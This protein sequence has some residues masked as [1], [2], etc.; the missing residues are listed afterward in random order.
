MAFFARTVSILSVA[1]ALCLAGTNPAGKNLIGYYASWQ[2]YARSNAAAPSKLDL[3]RWSRVNFAFM[4]VAQD[5]SLH[6]TDSY[7]DPIVLFGTQNW[8]DPTGDLSR[9]VTFSALQKPWTATGDQEYNTVAPTVVTGRYNKGT[10]LI[11]LAHA[12]GTKVYLSVGGWTLST[13]FTVV[14]ASAT[15]RAKFAGECARVVRDWGIDGI[16]IDWEYPGFADHKG[17]PA[18]KANYV[19]MLQ[20]IKDSL[21]AVTVATGQAYGLTAAMSCGSSKIDAGIDVTALLPILDEWNLMTYDLNGAW[22]PVANHNSPLFYNGIGDSSFSVAGCADNYLRRGVPASKLNVGSGFYGRGFAGATAIGG[23]HSGVD[24]THWNADGMPM[25]WEI[26]AKASQLTFRQDTVAK[27]PYATFAGGGL[28]SF[29]DT[30]AVRVKAEWL[31]QRGL[32]GVI[33]WEMSGDVM[34]D[35]TQPLAAALR[36]AFAQPGATATAKKSLA[37]LASEGVSSIQ[38]PVDALGRAL[39]AAPKVPVFLSR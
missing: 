24:G 38:A 20:E 26:M 30:T 2:Y 39:Q 23:T 21:H 5:G 3:S 13:N 31:V 4:Q 28:V 27:V 35:G 1:T 16:D 34:P 14:A 32:A 6:G 7:S 36:N 18:D 10:G 19:L 9:E 33:V 15:T 37:P 22:D 29:E 11:D 25:Y 12:A 17:T 8:Y